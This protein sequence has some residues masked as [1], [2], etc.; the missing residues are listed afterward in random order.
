[1]DLEHE[2]RLTAVEEQSKSNTR[3][4]DDLEKR[5]DNL[6][7]L[8]STVEVLAVREKN[9]EESVE[10]IKADVKT[11]T[12]KP[13]QRWDSLIDKIVWAIAAALIGF[14]LAQLGL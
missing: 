14:V 8:V 5:Q 3:R 11:L 6:D 12:G 7:K 2:K 9:V 1:M 13:G 10:E 4:L